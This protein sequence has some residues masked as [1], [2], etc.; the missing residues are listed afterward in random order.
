MEVLSVEENNFLRVTELVQTLAPTALRPAFVRAWNLAYPDTPWDDRSAS[1]ERFGRLI[2]SGEPLPLREITDRVSLRGGSVLLHDATGAPLRPKH[3]LNLWF[4]RGDPVELQSDAGESLLPPGAKVGTIRPDGAS[5]PIVVDDPSA[6][7]WH[8]H[9]PA[10][11]PNLRLFTPRVCKAIN[12]APL[13]NP[14]AQT[15][16]LNEGYTRWDVGLLGWALREKGHKLTAACGPL[17]KD[18]LTCLQQ[19]AA[20]PSPM[21]SPSA[22]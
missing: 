15:L 6:T 12:C 2:Q 5:M 22:L 11:R 10:P 19:V 14:N 16:L 3:G 1:R 8:H 17:E 18:V 13:N 7:D 20:V 4:K 21:P 9:G